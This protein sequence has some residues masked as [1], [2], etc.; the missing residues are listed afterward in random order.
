MKRVTQIFLILIIIV[1]IIYI[2]CRVYADDLSWE[3]IK[4]TAQEF[5]KKTEEKG[6]EFTKYIDTSALVSGAANILTTMGVI[7]ILA[8]LLYTGI[9]YMTASPNEAAD[10]KKRFIGLSISGVIILG[11]FTIWKIVGEFLENTKL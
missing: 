11:A 2:P 1:S 3:S 5:D 6:K 7:I 10:L 4:Q 8:G 9:R